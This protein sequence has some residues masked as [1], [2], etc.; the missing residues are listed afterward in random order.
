M[1]IVKAVKD[2]RGLRWGDRPPPPKYIKNS[3]RYRSTPTKGSWSISTG[4]P[5]VDPQHKRQAQS[6]ERG[7]ANK[8]LQ[9]TQTSG[10]GEW[11][12]GAERRTHKPRDIVGRPV[13]WN[14]STQ[15][16]Q[17][18]RQA[19]GAKTSTHKPCDIEGGSVCCL[20]ETHFRPRDTNRLKGKE[21]KRY[22]MWME[23]ERKWDWQSL[24]QTK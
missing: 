18:R 15:A 13:S 9:H 19:W 16:P 10:P 21:W 22:L 17:H 7:M 8:L 3:S 20:Q 12:W 6:A 24:F 5:T 14:K 4:K 11:A 23:T 1:Q 2:G